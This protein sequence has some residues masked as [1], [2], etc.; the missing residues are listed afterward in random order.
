MSVC[1]HLLEK[2]NIL[3]FVFSYLIE[4]AETKVGDGRENKN[5]K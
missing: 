1:F 2:D 4:L 3:F 5:I